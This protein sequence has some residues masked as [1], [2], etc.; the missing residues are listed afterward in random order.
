[1]FDFALSAFVTLFVIIDP[2]S[3]LPIFV[4]LTKGA[5]SKQ[6]IIWAIRATLVAMFVLV[7]FS[8]F[9]SNLLGFLGIGLP[10]FRIAGGIMLG[11]IALE[12]VFEKRNPRKIQNRGG[13]EQGNTAGRPV[14]VSGRDSFTRRARSNCHGHVAGE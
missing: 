13:V 7:L 8:L 12:M 3:N 5:D 10:A 6:R 14:G 2:L 1:M 11:Y 4:G 9:G